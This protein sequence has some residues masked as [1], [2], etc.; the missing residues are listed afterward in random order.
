MFPPKRLED[1]GNT[2]LTDP[3]GNPWVYEVDGTD[4]SIHS[5]GPDGVPSDDDVRGE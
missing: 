1:L 2:L 5:L 4:F 3:W